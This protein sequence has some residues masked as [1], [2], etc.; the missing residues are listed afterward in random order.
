MVEM[1]KVPAVQMWP[2]WETVRQIGHG[3]F[4]TVYE[5]K[6]DIFGDAECAAMKH[7]SI[8]QSDSDIELLY[9][10]GH[11]DESIT[12]TFKEQVKEIVNEYKLMKKLTDCPNVVSCDDVLFIQHDDDLGWDI[13]I[14]M[15]LLT[16]LL[17]RLKD[18]SDFP[19]EQITQMGIDLCRALVYCH[20]QNIIHRDIKPQNIFISSGGI[21]KLGDFG[22][23]RIKSGS[24]N[25]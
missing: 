22:I 11:D 4:G 18:Q 23:A 3:S 7:I 21:Y 10:E 9:S 12:E 20:G 6:K 8:P 16:P 2:G 5:I 1:G 24:R 17:K 13:F 15:E 19:E 25:S 14:K